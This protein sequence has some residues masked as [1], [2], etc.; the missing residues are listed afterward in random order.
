MSK[1]TGLWNKIGRSITAAEQAKKA[2]GLLSKF[3]DVVNS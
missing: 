2:F 1:I 3:L